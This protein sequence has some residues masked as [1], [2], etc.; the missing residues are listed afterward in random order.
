MSG[1]KTCLYLLSFVSKKLCKAEIRLYWSNVS[2][3]AIN[4]SLIDCVSFFSKS[5]NTFLARECV[6]FV[7]ADMHPEQPKFKPFKSLASYPG[8]I[9]K[10]SNFKLS[11]KL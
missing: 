7:T 9:K 11:N 2:L 1:G 4:L 10:F 5:S 6:T 3:T 8:N